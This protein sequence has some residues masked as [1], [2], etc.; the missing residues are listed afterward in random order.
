[1]RPWPTRSRTSA[2]SIC[3]GLSFIGL[4]SCRAN[5]VSQGA[6]H[7]GKGRA[8][9]LLGALPTG[10]VATT[11]FEA[12]S[13]TEILLLAAFATYRRVPAVLTATSRGANPTGMVATTALV[14]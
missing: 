12:V 10:T 11:A 6:G 7:Y 5:Q 3:I 1:M 13:T 9:T 14:L 8:T 2:G 4:A